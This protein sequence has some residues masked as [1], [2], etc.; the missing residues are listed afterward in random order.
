MKI[1][2]LLIS[3]ISLG[4]WLLFQKKFYFVIE[5]NVLSMPLRVIKGI[6][7]ELASKVN[8]VI[9]D[10]INNYFDFIA[11]FQSYYKIVTPKPQN[12][13]QMNCEKNFCLV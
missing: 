7:R 9:P 3:G 8:E 4:N 5:N 11:I 10:K 13:S 12:V 1:I 6:S 2:I